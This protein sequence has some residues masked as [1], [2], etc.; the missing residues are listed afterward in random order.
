MNA[1]SDDMSA[2]KNE[3]ENLKMQIKDIDHSYTDL[4][5]QNRRYESKVKD[6]ST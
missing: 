5:S 6:M 1:I 4:V 3:I 2:N